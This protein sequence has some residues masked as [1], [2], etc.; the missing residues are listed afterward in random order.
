M[1]IFIKTLSKNKHFNM[2]KLFFILILLVAF[3]T[4]SCSTKTKNKILQINY[5]YDFGRCVSYCK[6]T[7]YIT[8]KRIVTVEKSHRDTVQY[9]TKIVTKKTPSNFWDTLVRLFQTSEMM[10]LPSVIGCPGCAD[11]GI[12]WMSIIQKDGTS[13]KVKF[14]YSND[15]GKLNPLLDA[16]NPTRKNN[17]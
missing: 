15:M 4:T 6:K 16:I 17:R 8:P 3:S 2:N 10:H 13:K 11:E 9:P 12:E 14:N 7:Y 1:L 5:G